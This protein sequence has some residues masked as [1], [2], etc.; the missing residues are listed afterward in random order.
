[1]RLLFQETG[2]EKDTTLPDLNTQCTACAVPAVRRVFK[3]RSGAGVWGFSALHSGST[4]RV[5]QTAKRLREQ[6]LFGSWVRRLGTMLARPGASRLS[7]PGRRQKGK[8]GQ[9]PKGAKTHFCHS[10]LSRRVAPSHSSSVNLHMRAKLPAAGPAGTHSIQSS[11]P[12]SC[13][14]TGV[15]CARWSEL[16]GPTCGCHPQVWER[17]VS[18]WPLPSREALPGREEGLLFSPIL[19]TG[20]PGSEAAPSEV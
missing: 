20:R 19:F 15:T 6:S 16:A 10:P 13:W 5:P 12:S 1:M 3:K 18:L 2:L 17:E 11:S 4:P 9:E 8:S 14:P 7:C